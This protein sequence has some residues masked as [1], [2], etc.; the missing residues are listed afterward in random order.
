MLHKGMSLF[1]LP[2]FQGPR[3]YVTG[4][5]RGK[6]DGQSQRRWDYFLR[7]SRGDIEEYCSED[8]LLAQHN[9][10]KAIE[11]K[12]KALTPLWVVFIISGALLFLLIGN[13]F[14]GRSYTHPVLNNVLNHEIILHL[15]YVACGLVLILI[16]DSCLFFLKLLAGSKRVKAAKQEESRIREII[17]ELSAQI[18]KNIP[19]AKEMRKFIQERLKALE[20]RE[21]KNLRLDSGEVT[22]ETEIPPIC[23]WGGLQ[24]KEKPGYQSIE[25]VS[26]IHHSLVQITDDGRPLYCVYYVQYLFPT[27]DYIASHGEF[28]D[29][30]FDTTK[31]RL[32]DEYYYS[33][34]TSVRTEMKERE[35][36]FLNNKYEE[37]TTL[38]LTVASGDV[39]EVS[40]FDENLQRTM[41]QYI[42]DRRKS[43]ADNFQKLQ[44]KLSKS[45]DEDQEAI[46]IEIEKA[47]EA[48]NRLQEEDRAGIANQVVRDIRH[49]LRIKKGN[50]QNT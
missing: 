22:V 5:E 48:R 24:N 50:F 43:R 30:I 41:D 26:P 49:Q 36:F 45:N 8:L 29:I 42:L 11:K 9:V 38:R 13:D 39:V 47:K 7:T 4:E 12:Q 3:G 6:L 44:D 10:R 27:S 18:P 46:R 1:K 20:D 34:V 33:D 31:G 16:F 15:N 21:R 17:E 35:L 14:L 40:M 19:D 28:L 32:T 2:V 37:C 23:E 25:R